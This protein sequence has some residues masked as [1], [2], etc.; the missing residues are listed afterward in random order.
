MSGSSSNEVS[1]LLVV[2]GDEEEV[3]SPA[4]D[5]QATAERSGLLS[6][7]A[8]WRPVAATMLLST[9][10]VML[11][12]NDDYDDDDA[13]TT[14]R[15]DDESLETGLENA[16]VAILVI[17]TVTCVVLG[18]YWLGCVALLRAYMMVS[19]AMLLFLMATLVAV[20]AAI[21]VDAPSFFFVCWNWSCLGVVAIFAPDSFGLGKSTTGVFLV[22]IAVCMSWQLS[23]FPPVTTWCV[24]LGL[25]AYDAFAV[26]SPCGPLKLLVDLLA[27]N[28][29]QS[30]PGLL[31]EADL[32]A[33]SSS[34]HDDD[35]PS[36]IKLGLG[37]FVFYSV[38]VSQAASRFPPS[39]ASCFV[40][41]LFGLALTL[42]LLAHY[43]KPLPALPISIV[44][45]LSLFFATDYLVRPALLKGNTYL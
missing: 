21:P 27:R 36:T 3:V 39:A 40:A 45:G 12:P 43:R 25:A 41:T 18:L 30:L 24:L 42:S 17:L 2:S 6:F 31:Y 23:A 1:P 9:L 26:L 5:I 4:A 44:L 32:A 28:P 35:E 8:L 16:T 38:L 11:V 13:T 14:T 19:C 7:D 15:Q 29:Q 34:Q 33:T 20:A 37:D 10:L 22:A